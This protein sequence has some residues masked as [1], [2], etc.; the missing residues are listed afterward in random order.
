MLPKNPPA[1]LE[2]FAQLVPNS[3]SSGRPV[4]TPTP[5]FKMNSRPPEAWVMIPE[6]IAGA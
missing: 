6:G 1:T 5:K 4:T 2:K 3:N